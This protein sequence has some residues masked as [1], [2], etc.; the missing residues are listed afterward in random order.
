MAK[1]IIDNLTDEQ[2]KELGNWFINQGEQSCEEWFDINEVPAPVS[3]S[4]ERQMDGNY[5]I[6]CKE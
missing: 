2:A 4:M 3:E 1:L 6:T 5:W